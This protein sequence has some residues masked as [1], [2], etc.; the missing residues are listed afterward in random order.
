MLEEDR[1]RPGRRSQAH[2]QEAT[3][4]P[5]TADETA[6]AIL[7]QRFQEENEITVTNV[8]TAL[9]RRFRSAQIR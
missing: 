9:P 1:L 3:I 7:L 5:Q 2:E 4:S 8:N 6:L